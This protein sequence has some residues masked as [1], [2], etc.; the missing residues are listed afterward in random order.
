[1]YVKYIHLHIHSY[2]YT[3]I[4]IPYYYKKVEGVT[5]Q[6]TELTLYHCTNF[7]KVPK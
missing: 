2:V 1:M 5:I 6:R 7:S 4:H 3:Y